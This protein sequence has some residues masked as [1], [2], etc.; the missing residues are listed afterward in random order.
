MNEIQFQKPNTNLFALVK[1]DG[2]IFHVET[3]EY[4]P[5]TEENNHIDSFKLKINSFSLWL[6]N[7]R[8]IVS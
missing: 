1:W 7:G 5:E 3:E 4:D 8:W 6:K 2:E